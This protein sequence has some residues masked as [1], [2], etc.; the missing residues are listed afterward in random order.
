[1]QDK[2]FQDTLIK[3]GFE[4]VLDSNPDKA[5]AFVTDEVKRWPPILKAAGMI[6]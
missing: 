1:M 3:S 2:D 6:K 5:R 4:P